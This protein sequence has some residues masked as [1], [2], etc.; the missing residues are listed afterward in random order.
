MDGALPVI[1]A[2]AWVMVLMLTAILLVRR[3]MRRGEIVQVTVRRVDL[4]DSVSDFPVAVTLT[5]AFPWR[6]QTLEIC[7]PPR[8]GILPPQEGE[9]REMRWDP[10]SR[11]LRELPS[12]RSSVMPILIYVFVL[13]ALTVAAGFVAAFLPSVPP[14]MVC[15]RLCLGSHRLSGRRIL[16]D[17]AT[18]PNL[19]K[20]GGVRRPSA[21]AGRVSGLCPPDGHRRRFHRGTCLPLFLARPDLPSGGRRWETTLPPRR[22]GHPLPGPAER[23]RS[24]GPEKVPFHAGDALTGG[25]AMKI[26]FS[27]ALPPVRRRCSAG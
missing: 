18:G 25:L 19:R 21:G 6:G 22:N 27:Q 9:R 24:G 3:R 8:Q 2:A 12:G 26:S 14:R 16:D 17:P 13:S 1:T 4:D 10:I 20:A 11:R 5:Y 15:P 23:Q 7:Q